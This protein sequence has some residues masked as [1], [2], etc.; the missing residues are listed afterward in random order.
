MQFIILLKVASYATNVSISNEEAL[1]DLAGFRTKG[2]IV[3]ALLPQL[4][5]RNAEYARQSENLPFG[6]IEHATRVKI[7][8]DHWP[9]LCRCFEI[10]CDEQNN[11]ARVQ[12][13]KRLIIT[14]R[15]KIIPEE[16]LTRLALAYSLSFNAERSLKAYIGV[17]ED[18]LVEVSENQEAA[19]WLFQCSN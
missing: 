12:I 9:L 7:A 15:D 4:T 18:W 11:A 10:L 14:A 16:R 2:I 1:A 6:L 13:I 17:L 19:R 8:K 5:E 3:M